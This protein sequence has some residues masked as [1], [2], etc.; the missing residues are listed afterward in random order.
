VSSL[1]TSENTYSFLSQLRKVIFLFRSGD[2]T[3]HA[4]AGAQLMA[5]CD[6][7]PHGQRAGSL[8]QGDFAIAILQLIRTQDAGAGPASHMLQ[9]P[10]QIGPGPPSPGESGLHQLRRRPRATRTTSTCRFDLPLNTRFRPM[11]P[12]KEYPSRPRR[13]RT[14]SAPAMQPFG[15][16]IEESARPRC[17]SCREGNCYP[18]RGASL[19]QASDRTSPYV[20]PRCPLRPSANSTV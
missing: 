8:Q 10:E 19:L 18:R 9:V 16:E 15:N 20:T 14:S 12:P 4:T 11:H 5:K 1:F 13:A 17:R 3:H 6:S 2:L 7:L